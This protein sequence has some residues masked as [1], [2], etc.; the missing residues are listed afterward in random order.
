MYVQLGTRKL[1]RWWGGATH[2]TL[3]KSTYLLKVQKGKGSVWKF[4]QEAFTPLREPACHI[5]HLTGNHSKLASSRQTANWFLTCVFSPVDGSELD[6][7]HFFC[8]P[9]QP[10]PLVNPTC[11]QLWDGF[12]DL[13]RLPLGFYWYPVICPFPL[14]VALCDHNLATLQTD[15]RTSCF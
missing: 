7:G 5:T 14:F 1:I 3:K 2:A 8:D 6:M 15:G 4:A 9:T 12:W 11:V 13:R 10:D